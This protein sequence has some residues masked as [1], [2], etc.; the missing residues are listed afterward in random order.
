MTE[1]TFSSRWFRW[2]GVLSCIPSAHMPYSKCSNKCCPIL[3]PS[4]IYQFNGRKLAVLAGYLQ[5]GV[6]DEGSWT[7][8]VSSPRQLGWSLL[9]RGTLREVSAY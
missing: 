6:V 1:R 9:R 3:L 8:R 7:C 5:V 2:F 4:Q